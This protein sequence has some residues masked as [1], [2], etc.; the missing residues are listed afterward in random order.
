MDVKGQVIAGKVAKILIRQKSGERIELG[1]LLVVDD[2]DGYSIMKVYDL[3]YGSQLQ[4]SVREMIA[5]ME[6][7]GHGGDLSFF[8][9]ELRNYIIAEA[10]SLI[11]ITSDGT[12]KPKGLPTFFSSVQLVSGEHLKF[13]I[14]PK[15]PL[16]LG[17]VRSGSKVLDVDVFLDA[18]E[19]LPHHVLVPAITGRGKSNLV[20]V[21]LWSI[22]DQDR[23]GILVLDPHDEYYGRHKQGLKDHPKSDHH[24]LYYSPNAPTGTNTL[25]VHLET[26]LPRDLSG[27]V[28]LSE[29]QQEGIRLFYNHFEEKWIENIVRGAELR[30]VQE[31]TTAVLQR[32]F[33]TFLGVYVGND[34]NL[35]CRNRAFSNTAGMT[36]VRDITKALEEG[37][38]VVM[39]TSMLHEE[40]ELLIGSI[41]VRAVFQNH[42]RAKASGELGQMPVVSIVIE[43]APRVLGETRGSNVYSKV[44]REGRKFKVGLIAVSQLTSLIPRTVLTNMNTKIILGNEMATERKAIMESAAQDLSMDNRIIASLDMGEA[45]VSSNFTKFAIPIQIP[46]F[47]D[48]VKEQT[49]GKKSPDAKTSFAGVDME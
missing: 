19:I 48:Y 30:G 4:K 20:K 41:I 14:K 25:V 45:L 1:D 10:A 13:L 21:M 9:P 11:H 44:A 47:E 35:H 42:E 17:K 31:Q 23:Y 5:G 15:N 38:T 22:L 7:E 33:D 3:S 18:T 49:Q 29:A 28:E 39:D 27:I 2:E 40:A 37:Q 8:E 6:L 12:K 46:L 34:D 26:L 32:K 36:T 43:E 24:L 16:Y